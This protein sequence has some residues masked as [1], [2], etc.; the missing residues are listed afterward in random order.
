MSPRGRPAEMLDGSG[1]ELSRSPANVL[2]WCYECCA[3]DGDEAPSCPLEQHQQEAY[4]GW[5]DLHR[6]DW[7]PMH[8]TPPARN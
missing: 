5:L 3:A 8:L 7:Y 6:L 2:S 4:H 1:G